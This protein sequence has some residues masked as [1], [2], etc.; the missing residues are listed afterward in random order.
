[1]LPNDRA[2]P[3]APDKP[4]LGARLLH[5]YRRFPLWLKV[6]IV[7]A[8]VSPRPDRSSSPPWSTAIVAVAQG[9]RTVGAS[10]AV[11]LWGVVVF[12]VRLQGQR[13]LALLGDPAALR[14]RA[15]RPRQAAGPLFRPLPHGRLGTGLVGAGR[16]HR[17]EGG[18]GP[19]VPRHDRRVAA[20]RGRARLAGGQEHPGHPHVRRPGPALGSRGPARGKRARPAGGGP[21]GG[22]PGAA[23]PVSGRRPRRCPTP[24][25]PPATTRAAPPGRG[26]RSRSRTR[27][28]SSTR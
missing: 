2:Q 8:A 4:S 10:I 16:R 27:W 20:G 15:G 5:A 26:R 6:V 3:A 24:S 9:R 25:T 12:S 11:A 18:A 22:H 21:P 1:M 28:P 23:A 13:D 7:I 17:P 14:G 19:A